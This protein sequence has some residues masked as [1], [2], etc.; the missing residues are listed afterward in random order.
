MHGRQSGS[1]KMSGISKGSRL[2]TIEK[3]F[4]SESRDMLPDKT[5]C[6]RYV[7]TSK[8]FP[9]FVAPSNIGTR[10]DMRWANGHRRSICWNRAV[11]LHTNAYDSG[12]IVDKSQNSVPTGDGTIVLQQGMDLF[13][14]R[15]RSRP[16]SIVCQASG[17]AMLKGP[18]AY[19]RER[20]LE[21]QITQEHS[22]I[23]SCSASC[24][25]SY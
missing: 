6:R 24:R 4:R 23:D 16:R 13:D 5:R 9:P 11:R 3:E 1:R 10:T 15:S 8:E 7:T 17:Y 22:G 20:L 2:P 19:R 25:A 18:E 14:E 12:L 21:W